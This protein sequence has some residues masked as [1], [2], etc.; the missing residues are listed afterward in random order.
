LKETVSAISDIPTDWHPTS[1]EPYLQKHQRTLCRAFASYVFELK[2]KIGEEWKDEN[3][4]LKEHFRKQ[5]L[6]LKEPLRQDIN[7]EPN[8]ERQIRAEIEIAS[9]LQREFCAPF[10]EKIRG[11]HSHLAAW[12]EINTKETG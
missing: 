10:Y 7:I 5:G 8:L 6:P 12:R 11:E 9:K 2:K 1:R 4:W 3:M